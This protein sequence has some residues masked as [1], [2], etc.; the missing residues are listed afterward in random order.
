L[1]AAQDYDNFSWLYK[2]EDAAVL[3]TASD[4]FQLGPLPDVPVVIA[5]QSI[6]PLPDGNPRLLAI[7]RRSGDNGPVEGQVIFELVSN[8][9]KRVS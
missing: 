8:I 6:E 7:T 9:W 2:F 3:E 1:I 4:R 5:V